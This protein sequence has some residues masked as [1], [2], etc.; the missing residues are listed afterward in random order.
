MKMPF[1]GLTLLDYAINAALVISNIA[2]RKQDKAGLLTFAEQQNSLLKASN[3]PSQ[4]S[5][6]QEMLYR[7]NTTFMESD[8]SSL[9]LS[10]R[11]QITQRS[12]LILFTNFETLSALH[13]QLPYL[14][15]LAKNHLLVVVFFL[16]TELDQLIN[17]EQNDTEEIYIHTIAEKF[18]Y[19]K[20]LIVK[21]LQKYGIYSVLTTPENLTIN[22]INK[23][24]ELKARAMI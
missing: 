10:V 2:I 16:N 21:E 23:Y 9:L 3:Q 18:G 8:Y 17:G 15:N 7:Q 20:R 11:R 12:L 13:R 5:K 22:T 1:G 19:E 6:I 4:M 14:R 24:L